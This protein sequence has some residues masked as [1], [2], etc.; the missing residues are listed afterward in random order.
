MPLP[1]LLA[2]LLATP[3]V[4][5]LRGHVAHAPATADSLRL[6]VG[7]RQVS[8]ALGPGGDFQVALP[9]LR[10]PT[11][12]KLSYGDQQTQLY[13]TPG[14]Q[15]TLR[16]DY[17]DFAKTLAYTGRGRVANNYLAQALYQFTYGPPA[18]GLLRSTAA[19]SGT[20]A[21][22]QQQATA[23]RA[24]RQAFLARYAQEA[25]PRLPAAFVR[26]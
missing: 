11:P 22:A 7:F 19:L 4:T 8:T 12:T 26:A 5:T 3:P 16:L 17:A 13:L 18:P 6:T 21:E 1:L 15:L 10:E 24:A 2:A 14:D 23:L 25:H 20:P 9:F